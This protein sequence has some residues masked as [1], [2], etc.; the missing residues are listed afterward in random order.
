MT[1]TSEITVAERQILDLIKF[2]SN[3]KHR[4]FGSNDYI[5]E[6]IGIQKTSAKNMVNKL[7]RLGYL[8]RQTEG[9]KR[10]LSYTGKE[11][12]TIVGDLSNYDKAYLKKEVAHYKQELKDAEQEIELMKIQIGQLKSENKSNIET[13]KVLR[14]IIL[15]LG[16]SEEQLLEI[17][18][19]VW[20]EIFGA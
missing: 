17:F 16:M 20:A 5:G 11:Y 3:A 1:K 12:A 4:F 19:K 9:K 13:L 15:Q 8:S 14:S 2:R 10:Y 6:C 18:P 7:V